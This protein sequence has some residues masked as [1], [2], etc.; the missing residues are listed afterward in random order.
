M[1]EMMRRPRRYIVAGDSD[2]VFSDPT[3]KFRQLETIRDRIRIHYPHFKAE[4]V[5]TP[6]GDNYRY[7]ITLTNV[8]PIDTATLDRITHDLE[9]Q[10]IQVDIRAL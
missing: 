1:S 7:R 6:D 8:E 9:I 4:V 5:S 2:H 3:F 10:G